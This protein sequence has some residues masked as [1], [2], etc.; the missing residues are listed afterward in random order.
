MSKQKQRIA[1]LSPFL[2]CFSDRFY[3]FPDTIVMLA[4]D[5]ENF[6]REKACR[7]SIIIIAIVGH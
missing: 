7:I 5:E 6:C 2:K 4:I 1:S 3:F